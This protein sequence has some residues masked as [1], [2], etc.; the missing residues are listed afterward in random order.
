LP[1]KEQGCFI[2]SFHPLK[3][4]AKGYL[5]TEA[6]D[7]VEC[8]VEGDE[9]VCTWVKNSFTTLGA[10][11]LTIK[12]EAKAG[13]HAA[14]CM[15][16]NYLITLASCSE[17]LLLKAGFTAEAARIIIEKLMQ[18]SLDNL[19]LISSISEAL[20]GPLMRGD[21][22]TLSLHLDA[23]DDPLLNNFYRAA[24]LATLP[25]TQL[26]EETKQFIAHQLIL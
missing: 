18:S 12:P 5:N 4:F 1:L 25:L 2:A 13:Y 26:P 8:V 22:E 16:S 11:I 19:K 3:A 24:G 6:F 9:Q 10:N 17:Q 15:A 14:A 23:I 20:T 7:K 21:T